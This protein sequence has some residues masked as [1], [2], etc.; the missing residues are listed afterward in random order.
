MNRTVTTLKKMMA[1]KIALEINRDAAL[2]VTQLEQAVAKVSE[3]A[4]GAELVKGR[5][6]NHSS[7]RRNLFLAKLHQL[8]N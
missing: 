8:F 7:D 4:L 6:S 5:E 3:E 2:S 1:L